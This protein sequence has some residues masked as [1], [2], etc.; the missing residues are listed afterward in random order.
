MP[1]LPQ[2]WCQEGPGANMLAVTAW[3]ILAHVTS[4][5]I[6]LTKNQSYGQDPNNGQGKNIFQQWRAHKVTRPCLCLYQYITV[7]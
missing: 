7:R 1:A 4:T 2:G 6:P 3:V 5:N